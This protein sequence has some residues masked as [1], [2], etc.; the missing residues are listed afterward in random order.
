MGDV[1]SSANNDSASFRLANVG[2]ECESAEETPPSDELTPLTGI[3][4]G[5]P[6]LPRPLPDA[7][8]QM[9][10]GLLVT[11]E[12]AGPAGLPVVA[13]YELLALLGRGGMGLVYQARHVQTGRMVALKMILGRSA[14]AVPRSGTLP[15]RGRGRLATGAP[16]HHPNLR[17]GRARRLGLL[18][19]GVRSR[20]Q[21]GPTTRRPAAA[22][23]P[24]AQLVEA[25]AQAMAYAHEGGVVHRDLKPANILLTTDG[26]PKVTDF[27][28]A[29]RLDLEAGTSPSRGRTRTGEVLGT[30]SYMAPEQTWGRPDEVGPAADVYAL[31][32]ILY[33]CLTGRPPFQAATP[34]D[35]LLQV[36]GRRSRPAA[37]LG[38]VRAPRP[39][40][41]LSEVFGKR[42]SS[43]LR[44]GRRSG[45]RLAALP[46][47]RARARSAGGRLGTNAPM[48]AAAQGSRS[49]GWHQRGGDAE[50][51]RT[52]RVAPDPVTGLQH[53]VAD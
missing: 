3:D 30:P 18:R 48:G 26:T 37:P 6:P 32:T 16:T 51:D 13:G 31:G 10:A 35:T 9:A 44:L 17:G 27:G 19:A 1:R 36:R 24:A 46:G 14:R 47:R 50:P 2:P 8:A 45:R 25:V 15:H 49:T 53:S 12:R 38:A 22:G 39:R 40:Y 28:L 7:V 21:S 11:P 41:H 5:M 4:E 43:A 29:K 33:E 23:R 52:R 42:P 34:L 20:R